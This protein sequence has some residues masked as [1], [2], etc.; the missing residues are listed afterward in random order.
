MNPDM[1]LDRL[2]TTFGIDENPPKEL[3]IQ[4]KAN[5]SSFTA[6]HEKILPVLE[7]LKSQAKMLIPLTKQKNG[8][9]VEMVGMLEDFE[10]TD[11]SQHNIKAVNKIFDSRH[12]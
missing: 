2:K 10:A 7:T 11:L 6:F 1:I 12:K 5:I 3:V 4:C 9:Y 8:D